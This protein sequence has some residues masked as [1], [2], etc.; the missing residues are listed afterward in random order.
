MAF[1]FIT[2]CLIAAG[3]C[4]TLSK[5]QEKRPFIYQPPSWWGECAVDPTTGS[6]IFLDAASGQPL[7]FWQGNIEVA[8]FTEQSQPNFN[9][10][11][12]FTK[13]DSWG[14]S[15]LVLHD[16][17]IPFPLY[18]TVYDD[19]FL[20]FEPRSSGGRNWTPASLGSRN[21]V[22][23]VWTLECRG[24]L[25]GGIP[26]EGGFEFDF[27]VKDNKVVTYPNQQG[28]VAGFALAYDVLR[29]G[30]LRPLRESEINRTE[31]VQDESSRAAFARMG[32][33]QSFTNPFGRCPRGQ[34][35][36]E[37]PGAPPPG[38][39]GCGPEVM[40]FNADGPFKQCCDG[41]DRC[42]G[43]SFPPLHSPLVY[44]KLCGI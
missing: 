16:P 42:F 44:P 34:S 15:D 24:K 14:L 38:A 18:L 43:Q 1:G 20:G 3:L 6:F 9:W 29:D 17:T 12:N 41:H 13:P 39:N 7:V 5:A 26:E 32:K 35:A 28:G 23:T 40:P 4:S 36:R 31:P 37:R 2:T 27:F 21:Y 10:Y 22:S 19:G 30:P 11:L 8:S 25:R 33:R